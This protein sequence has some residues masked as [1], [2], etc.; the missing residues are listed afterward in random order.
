MELFLKDGHLS[1]EGLQ[2]IIEG[3]LDEMQSLE[4]AEHLSFCDK[5]L[6]RYTNLLEGV[7][8]LE[9]L[10]PM[11]E[12]VLQR[13]KRKSKN[14]IFGKYIKIGAA[15]CLAVT[16]WSMGTFTRVAEQFSRKAE[17]PKP[18]AQVNEHRPEVKGVLD[19]AMATINTFLNKIVSPSPK[20]SQC[21]SIRNTAPPSSDEKEKEPTPDSS[22]AQKR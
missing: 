9:P 22:S 14:I 2:G 17:P 13:L 4:A 5:C 12:P 10:V 6:V 15:A 21:E 1:E 11:K 3:S 7:E 8:L 20:E 19:N 18:S 16:L